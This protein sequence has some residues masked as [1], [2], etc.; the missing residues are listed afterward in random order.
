MVVRRQRG[1]PSEEGAVPGSVT[2]RKE[3]AL[4]EVATD[5]LDLVHKRCRGQMDIICD[6]LARGEANDMKEYRHLTGRIH[7][8]AEAEA[9]ILEVKQLRH[10][11]ESENNEGE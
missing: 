5:E 4:T 11:K 3:R 1:I 7:G 8:L 6:V 10:G 9:F 2:L